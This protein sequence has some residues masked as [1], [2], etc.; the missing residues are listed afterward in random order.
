M[1]EVEQK[2][3]PSGQPTEGMIV[4]AT[5]PGRSLTVMP[6]VRVPMPELMTGWRTGRSSSSPRKRR[7]HRTPF[8]LDD[9]VGVDPL[10]QVGD[11]GDVAADD[12]L[13][14]RLVLPDQLAHLLDFVDVGDDRRNADHVVLAGCGVLRR[15]GP[16]WG[17]PAAVQGAS[18][19]AWIIIRPQLRWNIRSENA[20]CVRVTWLW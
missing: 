13:G 20:P 16:A 5:S 15:S 17:S 10:G 12:D 4:A 1:A 8:A 11:V 3:Q 14:V 2:L 6:T 18:M 19:L 7:N 9:V